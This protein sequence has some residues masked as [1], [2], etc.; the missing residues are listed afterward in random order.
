MAEKDNYLV[1]M[2]VDLGFTASL[3]PRKAII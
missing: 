1:D 2:L 3:A